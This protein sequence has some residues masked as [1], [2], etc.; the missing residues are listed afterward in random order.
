MSAPSSL[1]TSPAALLDSAL[2]AAHLSESDIAGLPLLAQARRNVTAEFTGNLPAALLGA[3]PYE[4]SDAAENTAR[5]FRM[6]AGFGLARDEILRQAEA[7][8]GRRVPGDNDE[9]RLAR[10]LD[11]RFWL[12]HYSK[13][14]RQRDE[15]AY[16]KAGHVSSTGEKYVSDFTVARHAEAKAAQQAWLES[17]YLI[18]H[19]AAADGKF[20][21]ISL[22]AVAKRAE[23]RDAS[24]WAFLTGIEQLSIESKLQCALVTLTAPA[25]FHANPGTKSN[26]FDGVSTPIDSH[27]YIAS[28]WTAFQRDLDNAG[29]A[30]SGIRATEPQGDAT[31]HWHVWMHYSAEALPVILARLAHYF[32]GD[33]SRRVEP[34]VVRQVEADLAG[35]KRNKKTGERFSETFSV[36]R[37]GALVERKSKPAGQVDFSVI[38]R[39]FASGATYMAKYTVKSYSKSESGS[40]VHDWQWAWGVRGFQMFGVQNCRG[41]WDELYRCGERPTEAHA[42]ALWDAVHTPPGRHTREVVNPVTGDRESEEFE[43]GTA[44]FLRLLGGLAAA[45]GPASELRIKLYYSESTSRYGDRVKRRLGL[46]ILLGDAVVFEQDTRKPG[47][48][49]M[50]AADNAA[51]TFDVLRRIPFV[52]AV[53]SV[54]LTGA[55]FHAFLAGLAPRIDPET[56]EILD[57]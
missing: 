17:T 1:A 37:E 9:T 16:I 18:D 41:R 5:H 50:S 19:L 24:I 2:E 20:K 4:R 56:G 11:R 29:F 22:A 30:V 15:F 40:R 28:R 12:K 8:L 27:K 34:I 52:P 54:E 13:L 21:H 10:V 49:V 23:H 44:A 46:S 39:A 25:Q 55:E 6:R 36:L 43:G 57:L 33:L 35:T 26:R 3:L 7:R 51:S 45:G 47:Q 32:P 53:R 38:N 14:S 42:A 31:T 48:W